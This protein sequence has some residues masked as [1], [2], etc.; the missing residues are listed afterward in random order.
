M[1]NTG[2]TK[3]HLIHFTGG[4]HS[5]G[6]S[7]LLVEIVLGKLDSKQVKVTCVSWR[8]EDRAGEGIKREGG[9]GALSGGGQGEPL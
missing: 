3:E 5:R 8:Q 1:Q 2:D 4:P 9:R 7:F 6:V